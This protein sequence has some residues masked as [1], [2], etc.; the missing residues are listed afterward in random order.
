[1]DETW[2]ERC[3]DEAKLADIVVAIYNGES[4]GCIKKVC[5]R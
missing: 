4:G 3:L 5:A 1:M 2:R